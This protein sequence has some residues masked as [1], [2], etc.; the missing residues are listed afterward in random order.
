MDE[1]D[2]IILIDNEIIE[3]KRRETIEYQKMLQQMTLKELKE[4]KLNLRRKMNN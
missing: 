4:L 3:R 1:G 2:Q